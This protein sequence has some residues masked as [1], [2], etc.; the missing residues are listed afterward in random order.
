[1]MTLTM[2][3][4]D[5]IVNDC[6]PPSIAEVTSRRI[7]SAVGKF[8]QSSRFLNTNACKAL[9]QFHRTELVFGKLLGKGGFSQAFEITTFCPNGE[10]TGHLSSEQQVAR[11]KL[12]VEAQRKTKGKSTFAV[13]H[14]QSKF[15]ND[16]SKFKD[17][18]VD[19]VVEANFLAS[20]N[21][22]NILSIKGWA[23]G[24]AWAYS[25]GKFDDF[26]IIMDRMEE[27]LD[28]RIKNWEQQLKRYKQPSL[29]KLAKNGQIQALLFAGRLKI[30]GDIAG[31]LSYLHRN[32][33]IYRDLK[34]SN[35]GF[36]GDGNVKLFDFG[37]SR[38]MPEDA[39]DMGDVYKMSGRVGTVRY[40]CPEVCKGES[41]NQKADCYSLSM[42]IWEIFALE[43][44]FKTFTKGM[45]KRFVVENGD[46]PPLNPS[47]PYGVQA[48]LLCAWS[49]NINFR[50]TMEQ[51]HANLIQQLSELQ[52]SSEADVELNVQLK[53]C[54]SK[55]KYEPPSR[56][57]SNAMISARS[58]D[59]AE[60]FM[61]FS[62]SDRSLHSVGVDVDLL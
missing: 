45:H 13:K 16:P 44:P 35:I 54:V 60:T 23:I 61:A 30:A 27:T 26:F 11:D 39:K 41:Y 49:S 32:G 43:K 56:F 33:I 7:D 58:V 52:M 17:A 20:I 15:L 6:L 29:E 38:E 2:S 25:S 10:N 4:N 59:T 8:L 24:G 53:T 28:H 5:K 62:G 3:S 19:L 46:R 14:I 40:M 57:K 21:H 47:W 18:A 55:G 36:D 42:V 1:M 22:P 37:L 51:F 50:P 31:A 9:P 34:P 48:L 12:I